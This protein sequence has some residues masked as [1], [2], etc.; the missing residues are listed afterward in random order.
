MRVL[1]RAQVYR[2][3][4]LSL[5]PRFGLDLTDA[6]SD[7]QFIEALPAADALWITPT[8]YTASVA[9][10]LT[11]RH[12]ALRWI[13]LPSAGYD[14]LVR[15]GV[16]QSVTVTNVGN[17]LG[18]VVAEHA[19]A[20]LLAMLRALP[21]M[22]RE[23][24]GERWT[25]ALMR[26]LRSLDGATVT[27]VGFGAIGLEVATR[28]R[29]FG[30]RVLGVSEHG[31][32][33]A[34]ADKMFASDGLLDALSQSDAVVLAVPVNAKTKGLIDER[35]FA[36]LPP[37]AMIVNV[38][39]GAVI[40]RGALDAALAGG[41]LA[42]VALDVTD[43]EPPPPGDSLWRDPRVVLSPHIGGFGSPAAGKRLAELFARNIARFNAGEPLEAAVSL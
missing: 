3:E 18:P 6:Q 35:A 8:H 4:L 10:L 15:F 39:R 5:V 36:A 37:H 9:E 12:N 42:G 31:R 29:A 27:V 13:A 26:E 41:C 2:D 22:A 14:A 33:N 24:A 43:P 40:D 1:L 20:L 19:V 16:P 21:Q 30:A 7:E 25:P 11:S 17:I 28:V 32:P 34:H 38:A 23:Q